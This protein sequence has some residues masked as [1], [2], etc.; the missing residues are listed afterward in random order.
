[1]T[2]RVDAD[3]LSHGLLI[4]NQLAWRF[5]GRSVASNQEHVLFSASVEALDISQD[6][7]ESAYAMGSSL[8][9]DTFQAYN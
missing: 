9:D 2:L 6:A 5:E 1:L 8:F 3:A 4:A 7:V